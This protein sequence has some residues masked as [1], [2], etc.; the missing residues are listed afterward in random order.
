RLA[1]PVL[2]TEVLTTAKQTVHRLLTIDDEG[3]QEKTAEMRATPEAGGVSDGETFN[4]NDREAAKTTVSGGPHR[5]YGSLA[6]LAAR[7]PASDDFM[8][9]EHDPP[10]STNRNS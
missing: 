6:V 4:G 7:L 8:R 9:E 3:W 1:K 10:I 5:S 2:Q